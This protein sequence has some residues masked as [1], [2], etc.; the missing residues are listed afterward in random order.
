MTNYI[1]TNIKKVGNICVKVEG[2]RKLIMQYNIGPVNKTFKSTIYF[3]NAVDEFKD[4][5]AAS[6]YNTRN[7]G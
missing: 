4:C 7:P 6:F 3:A 1:S 5:S 2:D